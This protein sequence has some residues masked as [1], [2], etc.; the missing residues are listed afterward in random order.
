MTRIEKLRER[1][2][3]N[4]RQVRFAD[5]DRLLQAH[6]F[7]VRQPR[8]GGRHHYYSKGRV[9]ISIPKGRPHVLPTYVRLALKAIDEAEAEETT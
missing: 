6:G 1:I 8:S 2:E 4:P 3:E 5:L 9:K 7:R